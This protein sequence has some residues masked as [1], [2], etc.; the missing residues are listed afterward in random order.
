MG[1]EAGRGRERLCQGLAVPLKLNGG[2][3][4]QQR[5]AQDGGHVLPR[6][7]ATPKE[8]I[9]FSGFFAD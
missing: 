9:H 2:E 7:L 8:G 3:N 5:G 4:S 6:T 1:G